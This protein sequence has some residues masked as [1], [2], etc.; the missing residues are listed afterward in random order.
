MSS[1]VHV[2][3]NGYY[4]ICILYLFWICLY[5]VDF[6]IFPIFDSADGISYKLLGKCSALAKPDGGQIK[7]DETGASGE[8]ATLSCSNNYSPSQNYSS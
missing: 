3:G 7:I 8:K 6:I 5:F 1:D 4:I 2:D